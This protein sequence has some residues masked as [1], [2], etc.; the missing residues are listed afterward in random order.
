MGEESE[1]ERRELPVHAGLKHR[2]DVSAEIQERFT[3]FDTISAY[4]W[5]DLLSSYYDTVSADL[6]ISCLLKGKIWI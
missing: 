6:L 2:H 5:T 1:E 3:A 4:C